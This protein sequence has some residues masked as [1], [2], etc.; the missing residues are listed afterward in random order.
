MAMRTDSCGLKLVLE[1]AADSTGDGRSLALI[2][3][4]SVVEHIFQLTGTKSA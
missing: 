2:L 1:L 3:G 4:S